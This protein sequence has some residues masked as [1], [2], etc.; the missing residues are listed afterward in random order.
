MLFPTSTAD[1]NTLRPCSVRL[2]QYGEYLLR[3]KD[4]RFGS[5]LRFRFFLFNVLIRRRVTA[6]TRFYLSR[7]SNIAKIDLDELTKELETNPL[8]LLSIAR[9]GNYLTGTKPFWDR[10]K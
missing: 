10:K 1:F 5:Y 9:A 8:V 3:Y 4:S 7:N 2:E 6:A